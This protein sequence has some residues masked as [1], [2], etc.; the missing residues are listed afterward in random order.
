[1]TYTPGVI[2][3]CVAEHTLA[4][5][6]SLVRSICFEDR[7]IRSGVF[8]KKSYSGGELF[9]KTLGLIGFGNTARLVAEMV[10][11]FSMKVLAF[12]PSATAEELPTHIRKVPDLLELVEK[13]DIISIH[14]PLTLQ[15]KNLVDK[16]LLNHMKNTA[17]LVNTSR[18]QI[19]NEPDLIKAIDSGQI[20]GAALDCFS[21]EPLPT[22]S[23]LFSIDRIVLTP[24]VAGTSDVSISR[25]GTMAVHSVLSI[26]NNRDIEIERLANP[27]VLGSKK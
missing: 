9:G 21:E 18:G 10:A 25:V 16:D 11:S 24:H 15:T 23:P 6:L 27:Q 7:Q 5:I 2:T 8:N 22:D 26:L 14:A 3:E 20:A 19:V 1:V 12:H 17:F 13:S 4:L